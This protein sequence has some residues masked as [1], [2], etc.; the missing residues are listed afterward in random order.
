MLFGVISLGGYLIYVDQ[1]QF[2]QSLMTTFLIL[3]ASFSSFFAL[4]C[5]FRSLMW[6]PVYLAAPLAETGTIWLAIE[7][8]LAGVNIGLYGYTGLGIAIFGVM[9]ISYCSKRVRKNYRPIYYYRTALFALLAG[10]FFALR[11][12]IL[13]ITSDDI[14]V[15]NGLFQIRFFGLFITMVFLGYLMGKKRINLPKKGD[16]HWRCDV[17]IPFAQVSLETI[18]FILLLVASVGGL[19][20]YCT[21]YIYILICCHH[22][23]V[24]YFL[25]RKAQYYKNVRYCYFTLWYRGSAYFKPLKTQRPPVTVNN[26]FFLLLLL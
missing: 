9:C 11:L 14:G 23:L 15:V 21:C 13:Q 25:F 22:F 2:D 5:L 17:L 24:R 20:Y 18:G 3:I 26:P 10:F 6:G 16:F 19:S 12:F 7:W 1:F 8:L 4:I